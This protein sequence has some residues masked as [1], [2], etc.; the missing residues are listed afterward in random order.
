MS[1]VV[2]PRLSDS[3]EEGTILR[4]IKSPGDD[5]AVGDELVEIETDKANM[6]YEADSAGTLVEIVA[7]EGDTL[8]IGEVIAR[9]GAAGEAP[10]SG[11]GAGEAAATGASSAGGT[12]ATTESVSE[13]ASAPGPGT[14]A[15]ETPA[16]AA[17]SGSPAAPAAD[18]LAAPA[19]APSA[20]GDGRVK[21]SPLAKRVA[22]E[23]GVDLGA[24]SGSGPGGRI[25][26]AD[27]ERAGAGAPAPAAAAACSRAG[28]CSGRSH[29]WGPGEAGDCQGIDLCCRADEAAAGGRSAD[30]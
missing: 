7:Q 15:E 5:V 19:A 30:V 11:N 18:S 20:T 9:I 28:C 1:D 22:K 10:V 24:L 29:S 25:V 26:K 13:S 2:M 16:S 27:V 21:A 12:P 14:P 8:P 17:E 6:V 3:M 23:R 4:W